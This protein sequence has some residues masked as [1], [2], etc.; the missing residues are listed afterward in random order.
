[1][2]D[3]RNRSMILA[4]SPEVGEAL[5]DLA[6]HIEST[7]KQTNASTAGQ[8]PAPGNIQSVTVTA[9]QGIFDAAIVDNSAISRGINYFLEYSLSPQFSSPVVVDL[10]ASRNWRGYLGNQ[11]LYWRGYSAYPTSPRS[12]PIVFSAHGQPVAVVGGGASTGPTPLPSQG[13]G[14]S[15][16]S[17][18][19]DGGFGNFPDRSP[20]VL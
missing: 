7:M 12:T 14:T 17:N 10:G 15:S 8:A 16:G 4:I 1:M 20:S 19:A 9:S 2:I 11:T 5:D 6:S 18:A 3:Y 13:S